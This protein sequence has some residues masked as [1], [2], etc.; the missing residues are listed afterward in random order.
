LVVYSRKII[1]GTTAPV[2]KASTGGEGS[3]SWK[4]SSASEMSG[5]PQPNRKKQ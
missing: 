4:C 3:S 1:K 5:C 2:E